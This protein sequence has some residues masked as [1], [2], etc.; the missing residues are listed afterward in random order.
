MIGALHLYGPIHTLCELRPTWHFVFR[1]SSTLPLSPPLLCSP[2]C[3]NPD[4]SV[5]G[6]LAPGV[7]FLSRFPL[8]DTYTTLAP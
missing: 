3:V 2:P 7:S 4:I 8:T 6:S 5:T 1:H